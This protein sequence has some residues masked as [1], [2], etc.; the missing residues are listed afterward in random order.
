MI[1]DCVVRIPKINQAL[2]SSREAGEIV[3][4]RLDVPSDRGFQLVK[5]TFYQKQLRRST[6]ENGEAGPGFPACKG[7]RPQV[8]DGNCYAVT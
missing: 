5:I 1:H 6:G 7:T 3:F 2:N 8:A 4:R